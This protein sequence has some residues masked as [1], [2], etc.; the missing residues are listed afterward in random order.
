M[1]RLVLALLF[2][3]HLAQ[4]RI[5]ETIEQCE[6][7]YGPVVERKPAELADSDKEACV[8]SKESVTITV[9]YRSG[10]AW[11]ISYRMDPSSLDT[12]LKLIA[13]EG[14]WAKPIHVN[15]QDV[16]LAAVSRD[17]LAVVNV[18]KARSVQP[19]TLIVCTRAYG[20][21]QW[22]DYEKKLAAVA[23]I[24][25]EREANQPLKTF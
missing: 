25:K 11:W 7:R 9:E 8:F 17:Q 23:D 20:K 22:A 3:S 16:R 24:V 15:G 12:I 10:S 2:I 4:A 6:T 19:V 5:G 14:G 18:P 21:A 1:I 13:P